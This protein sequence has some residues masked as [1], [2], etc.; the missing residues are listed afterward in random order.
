M[1][2]VDAQEEFH[3]APE[4]AVIEIQ[5]DFVA[6]IEQDN[7]NAQLVEEG[8]DQ[9]VTAEADDEKS[10]QQVDEDRTEDQVPDITGTEYVD[11]MTTSMDGIEDLPANDEAQVEESAPAD[12]PAPEEEKPQEEAPAEEPAPAEE[13]PQEEVP[14]EEP[15]AEET[16][17]AEEAAV[18]EPVV[19]EAA[20]VEEAPEAEET[21]PAEEP[22]IE[23][24]V[25]EAPAEEPVA[26]EAEPE[27]EKQEFE[28]QAPPEGKRPRTPN[29]LDNPTADEEPAAELEADAGSEVPPTPKTAASEK[30]SVPP[31]PKSAAPSEVPPTPKSAAPSEVPPTPKSAAPSEVPLTPKS[32]AQ[33]SV[34]P[35]P[36]SAVPSEAPPT[37]RSAAPSDVPPT[38]KSNGHI[39]NGSIPGTPS[40]AQ[41]RVEP[42]PEPVAEEP[43][44]VA[45]PEP[46]P[47]PV[48]EAEPEAEPAVEEEP[49]EEPEPAADETATE[50][51]AEEAEPEA[52]E[53]SIEKTEVVEEES[54]PPAARQ[55]SP[56]P[57]P[58]RRRPQS[59]SPERQR[60]SRHADRDITS[61]DEDS[62]RAVPP[63]RMPT[64]TSFS[65]WSPPDKQSYTPISPFV[66]TANKYR[67]EYTSGSS[68]RPTN[69]Y[70][71]HFD[72]IVATG[73]F[74]SALYSTNRL[75]E[76]SRSRTRERKQAMRSQRSASNYYRYSSQA[77]APL[78]AREYSTPPTREISRAPSRNTSFVSFLDYSSAKQGE[79]SRANSRTSIYGDSLSRSC[80]RAN[81]DAYLGGGRLSRVDSYVRDIHTPYEYE[82]PSTYDRYR[83]SSRGPSYS[84]INGYTA[85]ISSPSY[86]ETESTRRMKRYQRDTSPAMVRSMYEGRIGQLERSLSREVIQKDR[87]RTEYQ[88]LSTKLDQACRQM[89]LLSPY[90][91]PN[92]EDHRLINRPEI[93]R[94]I[95]YTLD[96]RATGLPSTERWRLGN[97]VYGGLYRKKYD[98]DLEKAVQYYSSCA[99]K[100]RF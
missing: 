67:N 90:T 62:Y 89:E 72:D 95:A 78:R 8:D 63:P 59:P 30:Q 21:A 7:S 19:E 77:P 6:E 11:P 92:M 2:E 57:P 51:T 73:A 84:T 87:L 27:A 86:V 5:K 96:L 88:Q 49:A 35:T 34:P 29:D 50:P 80:S 17:P 25:E 18:E 13:A 69:M 10:A 81:V 100:R 43:E 32:A 44:P 22:L 58:A 85:Y 75:I 40:V 99:K 76:R 42:E 41:E 20:P 38:P 46:E 66:S 65:S 26:E 24:A 4:E 15:V 82:V 71:S 64:A 54:A 3:D 97:V 23:V 94:S 28:L 16:A 36:K 1:S 60:T 70:T 39:A 12:E 33:S 47:E 91:P 31:T 98:A 45:E 55:S 14:A 56:S 9:L 93:R 37:P 74:S 61:Y 53:E 68:Y 79:L 83:S 48:A 52:V